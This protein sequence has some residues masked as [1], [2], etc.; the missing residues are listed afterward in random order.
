MMQATSDAT[1]TQLK[2][3]SEWA[4][5]Q[6]VFGSPTYIVDGDPFYGQDHL[7][8]IERA[9]VKPFAKT[10]WDNPSLD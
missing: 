4:R 1:Q 10:N 5:T 2:N 8:L 6:N 9:L 7:E 3:N